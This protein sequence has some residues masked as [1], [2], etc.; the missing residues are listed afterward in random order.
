MGMIYLKSVN[1]WSDFVHGFGSRL[2]NKKKL[3]RQRFQ[4]FISFAM[5]DQ[6]SGSLGP[7]RHSGYQY[8][9]GTFMHTV[10]GK[11]QR[12]RREP[13]PPAGKSWHTRSRF[14][15]GSSRSLPE[16]GRWQQSSSP[17]VEGVHRLE[18]CPCSGLQCRDNLI[19]ELNFNLYS[20]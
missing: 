11:R 4:Y 5:K 13:C 6:E 7:G 16:L 20:A 10:S 12:M 15:P 3:R 14:R 9:I 19:T 1:S 17:K 8:F 2:G 18:P